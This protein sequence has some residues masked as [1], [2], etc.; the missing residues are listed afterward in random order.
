MLSNIQT[1]SDE[2]DKW[3][4][5]WNSKEYYCHK[6]Y[7]QIIGINYASPIFQ[8]MCKSCV[9]GKHKFFFWLLLRDRLNTREL[10][11]R[12]NM[13]LDD[14]N[15]VLCRQGVEESLCP[16]QFNSF[17]FSPSIGALG[18]FITIWNGNMFEGSLVS[19]MTHLITVKLTSKLFSQSFHVTNI[20]VPADSVEK[21]T[22]ISWL[23]N[24]DTRLL[25]TGF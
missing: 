25:M 9:M 3:S 23:Y 19:S 6:G 11:K 7:L 17:Q 1:A 18:G 5:I 22:F 16:N 20:Y 15:C 4:Y 12:K 2:K 14:Y 21:P 8:W 24:L 13:E 10:L